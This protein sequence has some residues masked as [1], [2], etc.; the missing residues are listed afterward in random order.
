V[1]AFVGEG[2]PLPGL[3]NEYSGARET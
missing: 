1:D 2:A 3:A